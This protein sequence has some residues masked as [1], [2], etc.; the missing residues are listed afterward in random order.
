MIEGLLA[1]Q[2]HDTAIDQLRHRVATLPAR[3]E[4]AE[5]EDQ[6]AALEAE[7]E[8]I[9]TEVGAIERRQKAAED[10]VA[11]LGAKIAELDTKLYSGTV[12]SPKELQAIQADIDSIRRHRSAVEDGILEAMEE[13]EPFD[14][15]TA[16]LDANRT[17]LDATAMH[18]RATIAQAEAEI[19]A[20]LAAESEARAAA[21]AAVPA[22][23][24]DEYE[25]LRPKL[26]GVAAARLEPGGRCGG[27]HLTLPATEVARI[28]RE[29]PDALIHCDQ[30][31]RILVRVDSGH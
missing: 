17:Q 1:V 15:R 24:L 14:V 11:S 19:E 12:T 3:T 29:P 20:E 28:K 27:C 5:V 22:P 30:C 31:G 6:L 2:D 8:G 7:A 23:L 25:R 16:A 4:L 13:R 10:E 21:A 18:L 26:G 9:A